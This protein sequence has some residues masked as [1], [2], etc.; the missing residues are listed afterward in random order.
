MN[1]T[2]IFF[3]ILCIV[4]D[5]A[6]YLHNCQPMFIDMKDKKHCELY[7][8][9]FMSKAPVWLQQPAHPFF[10][11][12]NAAP[13]VE[14]QCI[15]NPHMHHI[16]KHIDGLRYTDNRPEAHQPP[17]PNVWKYKGFIAPGQYDDFLKIK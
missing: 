14:P 9:K 12:K 3:F 2:Y 17:F 7:K 8:K 11:Q 10:K 15:Y 4:E 13:V 5:V 6:P 16:Q 1:P